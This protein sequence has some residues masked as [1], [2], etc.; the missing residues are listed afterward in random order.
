MTTTPADLAPL[1]A[2][3]NQIRPDLYARSN[4]KGLRR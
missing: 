1:R 4:R 3:A 2:R